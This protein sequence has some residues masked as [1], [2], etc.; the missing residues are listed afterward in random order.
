MYMRVF[1]L[2][3]ILHQRGLLLEHGTHWLVTNQAL[4]EHHFDTLDAVEAWV[5]QLPNR[6]TAEESLA[7]D[8]AFDAFVNNRVRLE[9]RRPVEQIQAEDRCHR[10]GHKETPVHYLHAHQ[11]T[12]GWP[13]SKYTLA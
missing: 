1:K 9:D 5:A 3:Q 4:I 12:E 10:V 2:R 7:F 11:I 13:K 6:L 8:E